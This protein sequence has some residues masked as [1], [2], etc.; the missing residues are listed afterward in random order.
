MTRSRDAAALISVVLVTYNRA[1][2]I[3]RAVDSVLAQTLDDWELIVVDDGSTDDT[4]KVI[5]GYQDAR[6]NYVRHDRNKGP[7]AARNTAIAVAGGAFLAFLDSDDEWV[8]DR[9]E[10]QHAV[11]AATDL[12][13]VGVVNCAI[14]EQKG[15]KWSELRPGVRGDVF[16]KVLAFGPGVVVGTGSLMVRHKPGR[17]L[18]LFDE[19]LRYGGDWE[20]LLKVTRSHQLDFCPD[21]L[22][23]AYDCAGYTRLTRNNDRTAVLE[24]VLATYSTELAANRR[25][26]AKILKMLGTR[27]ILKGNTGA[28]RRA[29]ARGLLADPRRV[30]VWW[31]LAGSCVA[32]LGKLVG[33]RKGLRAAWYLLRVPAYA[34]F[35][36]RRLA[37]IAVATVLPSQIRRPVS[38]PYRDS[39]V[40]IAAAKTCSDVSLPT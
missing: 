17:P 29:L 33:G 14:L 13:N 24:I 37:R 40:E 6:I 26:H 8:P 25:V 39:T 30:D 10:T 21:P 32:S 36:V 23:M 12:P 38:V 7:G 5:A 34:K 9:L 4:R 27:Q 1:H 2:L 28:G 3:R 19:S 18:A 11:F 31:W 16:E 22:I 20:Y 15:R 35:G